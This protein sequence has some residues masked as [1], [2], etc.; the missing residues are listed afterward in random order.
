MQIPNGLMTSYVMT[1]APSPMSRNN[2]TS[3]FEKR[4]YRW[5]LLQ[6]CPTP[7]SP[8]LIVVFYTAFHQASIAVCA[9]FA[10]SVLTE[11]TRLWSLPME[12]LS[13][14]AFSAALQVLVWEWLNKFAILYQFSK[15]AIKRSLS[16]WGSHDQCRHLYPQ[17]CNISL[18]MF[19]LRKL[20]FSPQSRYLQFFNLHAFS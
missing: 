10:T 16:V 8:L 5:L 14:N 15:V 11:V 18:L 20:F 7:K 1:A 6:A 3:G 17:N 19:H 4:H 12:L 2:R 9:L 13:R